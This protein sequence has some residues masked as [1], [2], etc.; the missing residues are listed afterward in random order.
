MENG[1][2]IAHIGVIGH[3]GRCKSTLVQAILNSMQHAGEYGITNI[4]FLQQA[5]NACLD[6]MKQDCL[7]HHPELTRNA[8]IECELFNNHKILLHLEHAAIVYDYNTK[9]ICAAHT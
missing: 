9:V 3:D 1:R 5:P 6:E 8:A 4:E 7:M 2:V